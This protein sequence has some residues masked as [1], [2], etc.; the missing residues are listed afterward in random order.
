VRLDCAS[1]ELQVMSDEKLLRNIFI[2]LLSNAIKFS[3]SGNEVF[4][5]VDVHGSF[6]RIAVKDQGIGIAEKDIELVFEPFRRGSN[7]KEING[8]GLGL[9]IVKKAVEVLNGK[10][11]VKSQIGEGTLFTVKF[12]L[13]QE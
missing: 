3:P 10:I 7:A 1:P 13:D 11:D 4:L 6:V 2:N 8:T 5:T 12:K 9:S